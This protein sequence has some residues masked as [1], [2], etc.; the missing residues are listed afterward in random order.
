L[1]IGSVPPMFEDACS[2]TDPPSLNLGGSSVP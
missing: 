2:V 1:S